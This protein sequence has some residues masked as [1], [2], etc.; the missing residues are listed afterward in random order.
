M[1]FDRC[2]DQLH[3]PRCFI[4]PVGLRPGLSRGVHDT[5]C[6]ADLRRAFSSAAVRI[7]VAFDMR[8]QVESDGG[9]NRN[10]GIFRRHLPRSQTDLLI[11]SRLLS[12]QGASTLCNDHCALIR[13]RLVVVLV[14]KSLVHRSALNRAL[15]ELGSSAN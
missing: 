5:I 15:L 2:S 4:S 14:A 1:A 10:R 12:Q 3:L 6:R 8:D 11:D 7:Y 13:E 9:L